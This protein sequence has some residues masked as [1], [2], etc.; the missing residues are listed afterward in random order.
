M[1]C[2]GQEMEIVRGYWGRV[3]KS[4]ARTEGGGREWRDLCPFMRFISLLVNQRGFYSVPKG[5]FSLLET[6][7]ATLRRQS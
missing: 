2:I 3:D 5:G 6:H 4:R 1:L 7:L